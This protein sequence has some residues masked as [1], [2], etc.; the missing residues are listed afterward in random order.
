MVAAVVAPADASAPDATVADATEA[1]AAEAATALVD[2][3]E[4]AM[5]PVNVRHPSKV[6]ATDA[7]VPAPLVAQRTCNPD[8]LKSRG[9]AAHN[10]GDYGTAIAAY[11]AAF[12]CK[13][14]M[15]TLTKGY[16]SACKAARAEDAKY[17]Y[18]QMPAAIQASTNIIQICINSGIDIRK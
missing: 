10:A 14:E 12:T 18:R 16:L 1:D 17:F 9:E 5:S 6:V 3:G 4:I 2:A 13:A 7:G 11:R 8:A 15:Q